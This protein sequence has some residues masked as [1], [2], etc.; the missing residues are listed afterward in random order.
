MNSLYTKIIRQAWL[1]S[2]L[3]ILN[4]TAIDRVNAQ[5]IPDSTLPSNSLVN[6][7]DSF[8]IIQGGT[9]AG[10]NLFHSFEQFSIPTDNLARFEN[11]IDIDNI[12]TRVTGNAISEI[13]GTIQTQG[14][15][16]LIFLNPNGILFGSNA[17]LDIGGSFLGSTA[18]SVIFAD[19]TEFGITNVQTTPLLTISVPIGLQYGG[20]ESSIRLVG[21]SLN[22]S[23]GN[24][25]L[26]LGG[27]VILDK[28]QLVA[29]GGRV[30]LGSV[31]GTGIVGLDSR[32]NNLH[33]NFTE[34]L[35]RGD[36]SIN[37]ESLIDVMTE[38]L[39]GDINTIE[40]GQDNSIII[41]A[42]NFEMTGKSQL[43]SGLG[44]V[45]SGFL[46]DAAR[47][48]GRNIDIFTGDVNIINDFFN[49]L[50]VEEY[51]SLFSGVDSIGANGIPTGNIDIHATENL[52]IE[53]SSI[54]SQVETQSPGNGNDIHLQARSIELENANLKTQSEGFGNSGSIRLNSEESMQIQS[55]NI[56]S[57]VTNIGRGNSGNVEI[58]SNGSINSN[59][60]QVQ[61]D[62]QGRGDLGFLS[63]FSQHGFNVINSSLGLNVGSFTSISLGSIDITSNSVLAENSR[64]FIENAGSAPGLSLAGNPGN[65]NFTIRENLVLDQSEVTNVVF[66]GSEASTGITIDANSV[67]LNNNSVLA[68]RVIDG[69]SP[70]TG[71]IEIIAPEYVT[72]SESRLSTSTTS[73]SGG[74][75]LIETG[76]FQI[77][78]NSVL[79]AENVS[80][81]EN[82]FGGTIAV[83]TNT[84]EMRDGGRILSSTSGNGRAGNINLDVSD[85]LNIESSDIL[86]NANSESTGRG[87][88]IAIGDRISPR[89]IAMRD[90]AS[91]AVNS[92]GQGDAGDIAIRGNFLLLDRDS[93]ISAE[94]ATQEGGN[95]TLQ[96][97]NLQLRNRSNISTTAGKAGAGGNGGNID[98]DTT[99]LVS[100]PQENSD[101]TANAFEGN[102]GNVNITTQGILGMQFRDE[103]TRFSDITASS[104]FGLDGTVEIQTPDLDPTQGV[105]ALPEPSQPPVISNPCANPEQA[106]QFF[107]TGRGGLPPN[108][109]EALNLGIGT[110]DSRDAAELPE[111]RV[112]VEA[113]GWIVGE[114]G[115][116]ILVADAPTFTP[117]RSW[118][119]P[120]N[121][122]LD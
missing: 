105:V 34:D 115:Q 71:S 5:I 51:W 52:R 74:D 72:L 106:Y 66:A 77:S 15:A 25:L 101:I 110:V 97:Q 116:I 99:L 67:E 98:I 113:Q 21:S 120:A 59:F 102:G 10:D 88:N 8:H 41:N 104:R 12:I 85:R 20:A 40:V 62:S 7:V 19:G 9:R 50:S 29:P 17:K 69:L 95:I 31:A 119:H 46:V 33:F 122:R 30:E 43:R 47:L 94:T 61:I 87:G 24:S 26:L 96:T 49:N 28:A 76:A 32:S 68:V 16:N 118:Q 58:I 13:D 81:F 63:I 117:S 11:S 18:S 70:I 38:P 45:G 83:E 79:D 84:L 23:T 57:E 91:I 90:N 108:P 54:G 14:S 100:I 121:C 48:S 65:L 55:S 112:L 111:T 103:E 93:L 114:N 75:I 4:L 56:L 1:N 3:A 53:Q 37:N 42:R 92:D 22:V 107:N 109:R 36:I 35:I 39:N 60:S 73:G 80:S 2:I 86:A 44:L 82:S 78:N 6:S 27:E 89:Q 64:F